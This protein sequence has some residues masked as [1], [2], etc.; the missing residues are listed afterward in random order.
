MKRFIQIVSLLLVM[1]V[2]LTTPVFAAEANSQRASLF[3]TSGSAYFS[4][5]SSEK[6]DVWFD[7]NATGMMTEL[8]ASKIK[9][10]Q[11]SDKVNW[12]TVQTYYKADYSQMTANG[13]FT[14][15]AS[16]PFYYT[17]GYY[18]RAVVT[19]YARN[20]SGTGEMDTTSPVL[21]LR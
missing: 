4:N 1:A 18:Y 14:Y 17:D 6:V 10:Q 16:V 9:V 2:F 20:S 3:F 7:V 19:L 8:G 5:V 11:S 15:A 21:D 13:A 12:T